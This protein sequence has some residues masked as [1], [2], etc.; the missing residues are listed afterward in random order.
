MGCYCNDWGPDFLG[1]NGKWVCEK[2]GENCSCSE[3]WDSCENISQKTFKNESTCDDG[4]EQL[5]E[6]NEN[7]CEANE[8]VPSKLEFEHNLQSSSVSILFDRKSRKKDNQ[9]IVNP[10]N[11]LTEIHEANAPNKEIRSDS[12]KLNDSTNLKCQNCKCTTDGK[13]K[14]IKT[15]EC[16]IFAERARKIN[17]NKIDNEEKIV[18]NETITFGQ[19]ALVSKNRTILFS[20]MFSI[21]IIIKLYF[22]FF[23]FLI[24]FIL[25]EIWKFI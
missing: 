3:V 15:D 1:P 5:C 9:E 7:L 24:K 4:R 17:L 11:F 6:G 20:K 14:Q 19:E 10:I 25:V 16:K 18:I 2:C 23:L 12:S 22:S 8:E 13:G 21:K